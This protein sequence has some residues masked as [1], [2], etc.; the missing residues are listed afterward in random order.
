M[1]LCI[2]AITA[3]ILILALAVGAG[4]DP[5]RSYFATVSSSLWTTFGPHFVVVTL[6]A[7]L[8]GAF[9]LYRGALRLG[10]IATFI[11]AFSFLGAIYI[12]GS[13]MAAAATAGGSVNA[14]TGLLLAKMSEPP[15]DLTQTVTTVDG[16]ELKAAIYLPRNKT[17]PPVLVYIH[18]GGFMIGTSTETAADLRWLADRGWVVFS[19]DYRLFTADNPTWN[20]APADVA[21]GLAWVHA[22]ANRFGGDPE[23][24]VLLGD[25]AGGNLAI[26]LSYGTALGEVRSSC[27]SVP[28][29]KAVVV[30]YPAV[31]AAAIYDRGYPVPDFEPKMLVSGYIG[32]RPDDF[33]ERMRAISSATYISEKAPPTLVIEPEKDG[34]VVSDSVYAFA[35]KVEASGVD[36]EVVRIPFANHVYDQIAARSIGNQARLTITEHYLRR[37]GLAP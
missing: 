25:S 37:L 23:R 7:A 4:L 9:A 32:G 21:C 28:L 13:I 19:I 26:N 16:Q 17:Y 36:I 8:V 10:G 34:L 33:P 22:N 1:L 29:P 11:S 14:F 20:K 30:Q 24:I 12:V 15:P 18:G 27:G 6:L 2:A 31:D 3:A 35:K 5:T